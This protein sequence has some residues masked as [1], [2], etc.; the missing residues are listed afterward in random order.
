MKYDEDTLMEIVRRLEY[1]KCMTPEID[2]VVIEM[3]KEKE[4]AK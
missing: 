2:R 3:L 4:D 1:H